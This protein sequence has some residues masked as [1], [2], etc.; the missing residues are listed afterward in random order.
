MMTRTTSVRLTLLLAVLL[1]GASPAW[2][3]D[4]REIAQNVYDRDTGDS[5]HVLVRMDLIE[6]DGSV[7]NRIVEGWGTDTEN[8]L[9]HMVLVFHRPASVQGTR[10]LVKE[11]DERDDDQWIYLPAL[12]RVRRIAASEEDSSFM[13]TDFTYGDMESR[14]VDEDTH[15]LLREESFGG[16]ECYVVQSVPKEPEDSQYSKRVQWVAKEI[17]VPMKAEFYDKNEKHLKT[18]TVQDLQKVQGYWTTMKTRMKNVQSGHATEV[19]VDKIRYNEEMKDSLFTTRFL[20]TG[21][22]R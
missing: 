22:A 11:R 12:K 9:S 15:R 4:G 20:E 7:K 14:E 3:L 6:S 18:M 10:F 16:R 5:V 8:D 17:W 21:R 13:G 2:S 19:T 1:V